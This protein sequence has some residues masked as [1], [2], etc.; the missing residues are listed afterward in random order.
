M[1]RVKIVPVKPVPQPAFFDMI[2]TA[3]LVVV[4]IFCTRGE[5]SSKWQGAPA[6]FAAKKE[7]KFYV[8]LKFKKKTLKIFGDLRSPAQTMYVGL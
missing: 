3:K 6:S 4:P 8:D 5:P 1:R 7:C 2:P